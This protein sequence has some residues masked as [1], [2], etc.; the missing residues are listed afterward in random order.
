VYRDHSKR[1]GSSKTKQQ[2]VP[3][4]NVTYSLKCQSD[5]CN[6]T[7]SNL[8]LFISH[9]KGH[10]TG[11]SRIACPF[12]GCSKTFSVKS[13]F[14]AH[15]TRKHKNWSID[16]VSSAVHQVQDVTPDPSV[17]VEP[18][19]L[20]VSEIIAASADEDLMGEDLV[21]Q[22]ID[23]D[24]LLKSV[25]L[26]YLKL[27]ARYLLPATTIQHII[28]EFQEINHLGQQHMLSTLKRKLSD[29]Q[30]SPSDIHGIISELSNGDMIASFNTGV[31]KS[32]KTRK[33]FYKSAFKY[34]PPV[35]C[36]LG[37]SEN[38][39]QHYYQYVPIIDSL[40]GLLSQRSVADDCQKIRQPRSMGCANEVFSDFMDGKVFRR[41]ELFSSDPSALRLILY[42]DAFEVV[43]PLGSGKGKHKILAVYYSLGDILPYNRSNTD[44]MQ[45]VLLCREHDFKQFGQENVF[46]K[47]IADLKILE[48]DGFEGANGQNFKAAL[49]AIAGDNLGSHC[50]GGFTENFSAAEYFCRYCTITKQSFKDSPHS[51]GAKRTETSY[52]AALSRRNG[53]G[54]VESVDGIKFDSVFNSL[55]YFHVCKPGL[56][57]CIA[58]DLFEG[59]I[60]YDVML[61]VNHWVNLKY[62]S[63]SY[64]NMCIDNF[65]YLGNDANN[66]PA[67]LK[68][69]GA[70][71]SGHAVQNW[72]FLRLIPLLLDS[73][74]ELLKDDPVWQLLLLLRSIVESVCSPKLTADEIA[75]LKSWVEEYLFLRH[76]LFP[77]VPLRPK[78]HY[79]AHYADLTEQFGPLIRFSTLRFEAKHSYF[80][81][82]ARKLKNFVNLCKTLAV[83]HQLLQCY[84]SEGSVIPPVLNVEKGFEFHCSLHSSQIQ[85]AVQPFH[86]SA[87]NVTASYNVRFRGTVYKKNMYLSLYKSNDDVLFG[88]IELI[89][90]QDDCV[91]FLVERYHSLFQSESGTYCLL[92]K[93]GTCPEIACVE[94]NELLDYYSLPAYRI[95]SLQRIALHHS[96]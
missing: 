90:C 88:K 13:S 91:Y 81:D 39:S 30:I 18:M 93:S 54:C 83:R 16:K 40:K 10:L 86:F 20:Q 94:A 77:Q 80:K 19:D 55:L 65:T 2:I 73:K 45:L 51:V 36:F 75:C 67:T 56:P 5:F 47:L 87:N 35:N 28:Q 11:C 23:E 53:S 4:M 84:L 85:K 24:S 49:C 9:L 58:H 59:V 34:V 21:E 50:I 96:F 12:H 95:D 60:A 25:A 44:Q 61:F 69:K 22:E 8:S 33:S 6:E 62:F 79:L 52:K 38:G 1:Q 7:F 74:L 43:N 41:N 70:K 27:Q 78:H 64:L 66:K 37:V 29:L 82:C 76:S 3:E 72:C 32:D 17:S 26:C 89:L 63:V 15:L 57:P 14:S 31:L 68:V 48:T 46:S 71:L 92:D 42:Q